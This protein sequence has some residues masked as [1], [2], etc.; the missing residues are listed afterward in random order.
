MKELDT[1]NRTLDNDKK[2]ALSAV[3]CNGV[4]SSNTALSFQCTAEGVKE[5]QEE[6]ILLDKLAEILLDIYIIQKQNDNGKKFSK[7][8]GGGIRSCV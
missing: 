1:Q 2:V 3:H 7:K 6:E 4:V 5:E 8:E